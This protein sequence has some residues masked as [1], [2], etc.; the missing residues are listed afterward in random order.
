MA[1]DKSVIPRTEGMLATSVD[2]Y[3][4]VPIVTNIMGMSAM[5]PLTANI[6]AC[7]E[8][9]RQNTQ[10]RHARY[11]LGKNSFQAKDILPG[12]I[13]SGI[14]LNKIVL[15]KDKYKLPGSDQLEALGLSGV[16]STVENI[17][18]VNGEVAGIFG[19]LGG[20]TLYQQKPVHVQVITYD[21]ST[22]SDN[23][24]VSSITTYWNCWA[25]NNPIKY[26]LAD[27]D[28]ILVTQ[29]VT[30]KVA[31]IQTYEPNLQRL[32]AATASSILPTGVNFNI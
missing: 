13:T 17:G 22:N 23:P 7:Y 9:S 8:F 4:V 32:M 28:N 27:P 19:I 31:R 18:E 2:I 25:E 1:I 12:N 24:P 30:F 15:Y 5:V 26:S 6:G 29:E 14:T 20:N 21:H 10:E 11:S 3:L 16:I